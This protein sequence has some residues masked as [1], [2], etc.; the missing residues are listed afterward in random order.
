M[1]LLD[2]QA[3]RTTLTVILV[4]A[5]VV[6]LFVIRQVVVLFII[7]VLI[8]YL[9]SPLVDFVDRY[10]GGSH[11]SRTFTLAVVYLTLLAIVGTALG[12]IITQV[13][14]EATVLAKALPAY[15]QDPSL[16]DKLPLPSW[17]KAQR[18]AIVEWVRQQVEAQTDQILPTLTRAGRGLLSL[19]GNAIYLVMLPIL[20][21]FLLRDG[22]AIR[23][24]II[25]QFDR[26]ERREL[27]EGILADIHVMLAQYMRALLLQSLSAFVA[28]VV[29]LHL[30]GV[31]YALLLSVF[32]AVI[33]II[34]VIGP[35]ISAVTVIM[36]SLFS[37]YPQ[38]LVLIIA[39]IVTRVV[40]DNLIQ[41]YLMSQGVEL[42]PMVVILGAIAGEALGG[43]FGI[44][45]SIP[46]LATLRILVVRYR[47]RLATPIV[48]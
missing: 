6:A 15:I 43:V 37:G 11:R 8:A 25:E 39:V 17:I 34:P 38:M 32:I 36:V 48:T 35:L 31:P 40:L 12:A 20:S 47:R 13:I 46:V 41:P 44:F 30:L 18:G 2:K 5:A 21:F 22:D 14:E 33:E 42:H 26:L 16:F 29:L 1:G 23:A 9:V 4:C 7:A 3:A 10:A 28:F 19:F 45:L 27:I 24:A